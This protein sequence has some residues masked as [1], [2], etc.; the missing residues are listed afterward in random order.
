MPQGL[1]NLS[2]SSAPALRQRKGRYARSIDNALF[3]LLG[4]VPGRCPGRT[5][6]GVVFN[7]PLDAYF[8]R[9][10]FNGSSVWAEAIF[11]QNIA[12]P[13]VGTNAGGPMSLVLSYPIGQGTV[14]LSGLDLDLSDCVTPPLPPSTQRCPK[15]FPYP[16]QPSKLGEHVLCYDNAVD[17][18]RGGG[19]CD[20]WC[21]QRIWPSCGCSCGCG[22]PKSGTNKS[23]CPPS[24]PPPPGPPPPPPS[25]PPV[26]VPKDDHL[27]LDLYVLKVLVEAA[28]A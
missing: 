9:G 25:P 4:P 27:L 23:L 16:D 6:S 24:P 19:P 28:M 15:E 13:G 20:S 7:I 1:L 12:S 8:G 26:I 2:S 17:A 18:A 14:V 11:A 21:T 22:C 3:P 10:D 5:R